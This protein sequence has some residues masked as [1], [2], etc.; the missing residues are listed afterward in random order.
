MDRQVSTN[1]GILP[2]LVLLFFNFEYSFKFLL[3]LLGKKKALTD[4]NEKKI[5][6]FVLY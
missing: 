6:N 1:K 3:F 4:D 2:I 5:Y